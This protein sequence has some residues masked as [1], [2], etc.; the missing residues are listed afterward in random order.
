MQSTDHPSS[1][2]SRNDEEGYSRMF[3]GLRLFQVV[4]TKNI[5]RCA[6]ESSAKLR[7]QESS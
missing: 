3:E 1:W 7:T 6:V 5:M 2:R 4:K